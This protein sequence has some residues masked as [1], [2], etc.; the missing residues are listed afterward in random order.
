MQIPFFND[1]MEIPVDV[2]VPRGNPRA[3]VLSPEMWQQ[4]AIIEKLPGNVYENEIGKF[5]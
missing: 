2:F 3:L 5:F 4:R 1:T